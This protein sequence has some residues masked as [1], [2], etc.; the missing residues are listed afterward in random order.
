MGS[1]FDTLIALTSPTN[2]RLHPDPLNKLMKS[3]L[4]SRH[5][6]FAE[7]ISILSL[8]L[9]TTFAQG[10]A[11]T[12][13]GRL[14]NGGSLANGSYDLVFTLFATNRGG[15]ALASPATNS[16]T[17]VSNGLFIALVDFGAGVFTG[18]SNWLELAV[19]TN[20]NGDFVP[21]TPRQPLTPAPY[22]IFALNAASAATATTATNITGGLTPSQLPAGAVLATTNASNPY[23]NLAVASS[24]GLKGLTNLDLAN[25]LFGNA[26]HLRFND[27]VGLEQV[28]LHAVKN[29]DLETANDGTF[30]VGH[31]YTAT[32]DH[33][34][35]FHVKH[36]E[37]LTVDNNL[38]ETVHASFSLSVDNNLSITA[39]TNLAILASGGVGLGT[40]SPQANLHIYSANNPTVVRVQSSGTPGF[41]RLE[42]VSDP[43][44]DASE[45]R[46][47][48]IE[49]VDAGSFTGGL[50][51]Y[52]NGTGAKNKFGSYE[53]MRVING[54]VGIGTN[55]PQ[56][57]LDV[58]G[59]FRVNQGSTFTRI[60]DGSFIAGPSSS[61]TLVVTNTFPVAFSSVPNITLTPI[62]QA[63]TDY[64]DVFCLT[65]RRIT[66]TSVVINIYRI[67]VP[68]G[69]SN[70]LRIAYHAWE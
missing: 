52:V 33:D 41:G 14:N 40:T 1:A 55:S 19:R 67:D 60:Q 45:W 61:G 63:G 51:F 69:W 11:F 8:S 36:D 21:L 46:P 48:Y 16:A 28:W 66:T 58:N 68:V 17:V 24:G 53:A 44:G 37:T 2:Q 62:S 25:S 54:R 65:V 30:W 10:T 27:A 35:T 13:Q 49:S 43:Q 3:K 38:T 4:T 29:M 31:D 7:F 20:G 39:G 5:L 34:F 50:G 23:L 22:A 47:G 9:A 59:S 70:G 42:F 32:I 56:A 12:Y 64:P 18:G 15:V 26:N 57:T 6:A